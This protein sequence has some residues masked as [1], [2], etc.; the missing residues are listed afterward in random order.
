M[1]KIINLGIPHVGEN[2]F[3]NIGTD[4][5]CQYFLVSQTW[6]V[7]AE[8]VLLKRWKIKFFKACRTGKTKIVELLLK[9]YES[10]DIDLNARNEYGQTAFISACLKGH[11]D[12]V[13]LLLDNSDIDLNVRN[14]HGFNAFALACYSGHKDVVELLLKIS[15]IEVN[16]RSNQET[17]EEECTALMVACARGNEDVVKLLVGNSNRNIDLNA[18]TTLGRTALMIACLKGHKNVIKLLMDISDIDLNARTNDGYTAFAIACQLGHKGVV[19]LFLK[20]SEIDVNAKSNDGWTAFMVACWKGR[21][22]VVKLL[23]K[24]P[25]IN[26]ST[27][28]LDLSKEM[29][30]IV[31]NSKKISRR[32]ARLAEKNQSSSTSPQSN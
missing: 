17:E 21:K 7:L 18:K 22:K 3:E 25:E 12:V 5:L 11:K 9:H 28:G 14:N 2:I 19:E 10:E 26:F 8:N 23:L 30:D 29:N 32:S 15:D 31:N 6:K 27:T 16:A 24:Y 1:E 4:E 13:K 20:N